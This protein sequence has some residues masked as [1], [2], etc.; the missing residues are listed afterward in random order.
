M[1]SSELRDDSFEASSREVRRA[2][3]TFVDEAVVWCS[4]C[5]RLRNITAAEHE[6]T[7]RR[8]RFHRRRPS[9]GDA[10]RIVWPAMIVHH[11]AGFT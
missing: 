1:A 4:T 6:P 8:D 7:F 2:I 9:P 3:A 5:P 10:R 11:Q